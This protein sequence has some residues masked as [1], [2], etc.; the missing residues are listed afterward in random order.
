MEGKR[1]FLI[2]GH[3]LLYRSYYAIRRLSNSKGFPTNAIYGFVNTLKRIIDREKPGYL[4]VVFDVKGPTVRHELFKDYKAQRKPM[5]DDL[6]VQL[7]V[8]KEVLKALRVPVVEYEKYEADDVL[9]S[10]AGQAGAAGLRTVVVTTDKDLLQTISETNVVYNPAKDVVIDR[11]SVRSFFGVSADRIVDVLALW[12]DPSDN[13][14]GVPGIGEKT[15]KALIEE[16]GSLDHLLGNLESVRNPRIREKIAA[17]RESIELSRQLVTVNRDLPMEANIDDYAVREPDTTEAARLFQ[18]LEFTTLASAFVKQRRPQEK[19]CRIIF[20]KTELIELASR[21]EKADAFALDTETNSRF[22]TR[23]RL[24]G[25]SFSLRPGEAFYV[26]VGHDYPGAPDQVPKAE[27]LAVL[28]K[29]LEDPRIQK[30]G[31]NIKYDAI[32]LRREGLELGGIRTDS[33]V[34][35]YLLEPNWGKHNLE[36]L[37]LAYLQVS[38]TPYEE[39]AGKGK[40]QVSLNAVG[41]DRVGPYACQDADLALEL[42]SLLTEQVRERGLLRLYEEIERP[43]IELLVQ[44]ELWGVRVDPSVLKRLSGEFERELGTL[45]KTIHELAG[46][47]FNIKSPV[48]LREVLFHKLGLPASKKTKVTKGFATSLDILE[49]LALLHPLP[50]HVLEYRQISKLKSTYADALPQL[51]NPETAGSIPRTTKL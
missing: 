11:D 7:P 37:A 4:A 49:E 46:S 9:A 51:I 44:M 48:Q 45:E 20:H 36:R 28:R 17:H 13:I 38:K 30:S 23:A 40:N 12:G 41:V 24:V 25:L 15:A 8:L 32:V 5:P 43:L 47:P 31:Q 33:M 26:P 1:F 2:D 3:S 22:P 21:L 39:I 6:Q 35:S 50:R 14:P 29:A 16:H 10:I 34:L 42:G 27:A 19:T 18:E